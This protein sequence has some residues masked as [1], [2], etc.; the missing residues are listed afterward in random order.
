VPKPATA[1]NGAPTKRASRSEAK[2]A[3]ARAALEPLADGERP[4]AVTIAAIVAALLGLANSIP[5]FAGIEFR[6]G[7]PQPGV[8]VFSVVLL[9]AAWGMWRARYWAVLGMQAL[10]ALIILV[11]SLFLVQAENVKSALIALVIVAAAGVLF[12]K[13]VGAMARIQM[14]ERR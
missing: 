6:G 10:L 14:P 12:W 13:L 2:D 11:F 1:A 7:E 5:Y 9:I 8:L 4:Q 3:A